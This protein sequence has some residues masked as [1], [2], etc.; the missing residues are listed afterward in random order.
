M[1]R[2]RAS[3]LCGFLSLIGLFLSIQTAFS[4]H[5]TSKDI[6]VLFN[7]NDEE[8]ARLAE[9]YRLARDVPRD[10]I[11][12]LKMPTKKDITRAE[13]DESILIPLREHFDENNWWERNRDS[14]G[15]LL[16]SEN[17][18][19]A[20]LLMRGVPLRI[21]PTSTAPPA[22]G[23]DPISPRDESSVD[24]E[25]A[26]FG[27]ETLPTK[28]VLKN[29]FYESKTE[30]TRTPY[31]F[32]VLTSRI[33]A[34]TYAICK[35]MITDAIATE[36]TGLWGRAYVDIANKN[37]EG[38]EWL[39]QI[40]ADNLKT[41]IP[42]V[43]DRFNDTFPKNYPLTDASLY[44]GWYDWNVSGPF[45]NPGFIFRPGAVAI[46]IHSFSAEQ[47]TDAHK[48]WS[49]PLL[50]RGAAATVG[51]VYEPYLQLTHNFGILH[52]RLLKGWTFAEAAWASI[53]VT[54]WQGIILGDPLYRPFK[55][56]GGTGT[57]EPR[58]R[59]FRAMAAA[60]RQWPND[61][62][63]R[64]DKLAGAAEKLSSGNL[65]EGL[66]LEYLEAKD[67]PT[68]AGW[69]VKAKSFYKAPEDKIRQDIQLIA[70]ERM[71]K[72]NAAAISALR[73]AQQEYTRLPEADALAGWLDILDPPAPPVADPTK[74]PK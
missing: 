32:L 53:P 38:D 12:G 25:L 4:Q 42:T 22:E 50:V 60:A 52:N 46:H 16:P 20:I 7:Q 47:L 1:P 55:H 28:G 30:F 73:S 36:K 11:L 67:V 74:L 2:N 26:M 68:A 57:N 44:Y 39:E 19:R 17:K 56:I 64:M 33:D 29:Q 40:V 13:Y 61:P 54:S 72:N 43:A 58:D 70:I 59:D 6:L 63:E 49:A 10:Q 14:Q 27:I 23:K 34:P 35:R 15:L 24:S 31:P 8:S 37:P 5:L 48:N 41:G 51:N 71:R 9:D 69:F 18:I 62:E 3:I 65:A 21:T 45:L 66:A